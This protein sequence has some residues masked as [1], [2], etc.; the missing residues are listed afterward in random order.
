MQ[1]KNVVNR[2]NVPSV[3]MN[4][5]EDFLE[6]ILT[7]HILAAAMDYLNMTTLE[8]DPH[9]SLLPADI[10]SLSLSRKKEIVTNIS[11]EIV[12]RYTNLDVPHE[13]PPAMKRDAS[14]DGVYEYACETLTLS[15][16][17][18][19][20]HD[21]IR[22][23]DGPRDIR[24]WKFLL[25]AFKASHKFN[26]AIEAFTLLA[27][28]ELLFPERLRQQLLWSRF[29]NPQGKPGH[30]IPC[31]LHLEHC[32]RLVKTA[33]GY[34]GANATPKAITRIGKCAG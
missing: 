7:S 6:L 27:Q 24:C 21:S 34:L 29:V 3:H 11:K 17:Y 8:D 32:N 26:Y 23:G 33:V 12:I 19:E 1:L 30:N 16:L 14:F 9:S 20:F 18:E 13:K 5:C 15:L 28:Y 4:A 22:E 25:L 31:D 10:A 2:S